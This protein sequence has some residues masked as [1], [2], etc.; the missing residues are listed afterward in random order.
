M[1]ASHKMGLKIYVSDQL[2]YADLAC[3][4]YQSRKFQ[5]ATYCWSTLFLETR[6]WMSCCCRSISAGTLLLPVNRRWQCSQVFKD[7]LSELIK[8]V[9]HL[10]SLK[11]QG[12]PYLSPLS[13]YSDQYHLIWFIKMLHQD[14]REKNWYTNNMITVKFH[15]SCFSFANHFCLW[16]TYYI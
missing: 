8:R 13:I 14:Q 6:N 1:E 2:G 16:M 5:N 15:W 3:L 4:L 11:G 9:G 12:Q 7:K 10:L